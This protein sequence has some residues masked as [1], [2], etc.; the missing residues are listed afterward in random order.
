MLEL[1]I[2]ELIKIGMFIVFFIN[3]I[4]FKFVVFLV[5]FFVKIILLERKNFVV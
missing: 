4:F 3:C 2:F 1:F 5:V